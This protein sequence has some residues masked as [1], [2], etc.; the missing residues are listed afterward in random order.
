MTDKKREDRR[1]RRTRKLL[2]SAL[3][4]LLRKKPLSKIHIKE[5]VEVA[6]VSRPTFYQHFDTK[7]KLLFSHFDDLIETIHEVVFAQAKEDETV[8]MLRLLTV[9]YEQWQLH[10]E[11]LQWVLQVENK[12]LLIASLYTHFA[13]LKS[14]LDKHEPLHESSFVYEEYI[15]GFV[16]G[17]AYMLLKM[18]L[19]NGMRESAA[20]MARLTSLLLHNGFSPSQ[21]EYSKNAHVFDPVNNTGLFHSKKRF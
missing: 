1:V 13:A 16:S 17:G 20:E 19:G 9:S 8:D 18:W 6:D 2:Q 7:E 11:E 5:I 3:I 4:Q 15:L 21:P 14:E 12:D 10:N